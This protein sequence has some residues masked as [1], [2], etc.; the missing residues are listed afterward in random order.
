VLLLAAGLVAGLIVAAFEPTLYRARVTLVVE[1]NGKPDAGDTALARSFAQL[2]T[3][4]IVLRNVSQRLGVEVDSARLHVAAGNGVIQ[5]SYDAG[6]RVAAVRVV[7]QVATDFSQAVASRFG[8]GGVQAGVFD[9]AHAAGR[10]SPHILRD[11]GLGLLAGLVAGGIAWIR[12]RTGGLRERGRWRVSALAAL[13]ESAAAD[14]PQRIAEWR[15]YIAVLR[16]QADD[17]LLPYAFDTV[18]REVFGPLLPG[19]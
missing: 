10:V 4:D 5:L 7:Q 16:G 8:G 3:S 14:H 13:V 9:P 12:L 6:S 2:A 15:A 19:S 17:D 11:A 1:R 18:V